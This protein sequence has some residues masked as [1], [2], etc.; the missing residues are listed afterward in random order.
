MI[1][2]STDSSQKSHLPLGPVMPAP[3]AGLQATSVQSSPH[4]LPLVPSKKQKYSSRSRLKKHSMRK[5]E[6]RSRRKVE[7][8]GPNLKTTA[9]M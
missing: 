5:M 7:I 9:A 3:S 6:L 2:H 1:G 8:A 4:A